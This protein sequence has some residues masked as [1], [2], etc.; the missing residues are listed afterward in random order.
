MDDLMTLLQQ[1]EQEWMSYADQAASFLRTAPKGRVTIHTCRRKYTQFLIAEEDE[2]KPAQYAGPEKKALI[3][4]LVQKDYYARILYHLD[5]ALKKLQNFMKSYNPDIIMR[6]Y[7]S[8]PKARK[9]LVIPLR[10]EDEDF[11]EEWKSRHPPYA[12]DI[13]LTDDILTHQNEAVRSKS[14]KIIA[15]ELSALGIPYLYETALSLKGHGTVFPDFT[16]LNVRT[17]RTFYYEHFGRMDEPDYSAKTIRKILA[18][19]RN[20]F[21]FGDGLLYSFESNA[22][23]LNTDGLVRMLHRY[24]L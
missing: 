15:D 20:G 19:E 18:Y 9:E 5:P 12:N 23:P 17:R 8:L 7:A 6:I 11:I 22:V 3:R 1:K 4:Q 24:L 13:P 16:L 21:W 14:E 2:T 10:P